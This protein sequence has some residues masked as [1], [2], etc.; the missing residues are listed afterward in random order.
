MHH[1]HLCFENVWAAKA[2]TIGRPFLSSPSENTLPCASSSGISEGDTPFGTNERFHF[3]YLRNIAE[4]FSTS[5]SRARENLLL[6]VKS[7]TSCPPYQ[8]THVWVTPLRVKHATE[9]RE[10]SVAEIGDLMATG[11]NGFHQI[12]QANGFQGKWHIYEL[13]FRVREFNSPE[14]LFGTKVV[15]CSTKHVHWPLTL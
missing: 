12:R 15:K 13:C 4:P 3:K 6:S 14:T 9:A 8:T 10:R 11:G 1:R 5:K 2:T 7:S